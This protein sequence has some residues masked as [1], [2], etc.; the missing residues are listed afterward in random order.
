MKFIYVDESGMAEE[1]IGIMVGVIADSYRMRPTKEA[2]NK[3]L[4]AL[5]RIIGRRIDEIHTRDFYSG[6]SPWRK[7]NGNQRSA[8]ITAIFKW[9]QDRKHSIVYSAV[10]KVKFGE[11][12]NEESVACD[13]STLWRF[14]ALHISLSLQ[15]YYQGSPRG[16][17]R[18]VNQKG[19]FVLIFDNEVREEKHFTDLILDAPEWTDSYYNRLPNQDKLSQIVDVP[20]FVDSKDVGLIQLSDFMCFFL[21]KHIELQ[22]GYSEPSY[23]D[24]KKKVSEWANIIIGQSIP[25]S[26]CYLARGRCACAELFCKYAPNILL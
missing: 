14:L 24:E 8:I 7:L 5:S 22:M 1:P 11:S 6:N 19:N 3:L 9:L 23:K 4:S 15:K 20:H 13:I 10:D 21:R 12:F 18:T 17:N 16:R 26:N 25:K 2:W